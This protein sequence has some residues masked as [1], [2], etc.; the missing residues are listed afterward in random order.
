MT[1]APTTRGERG[2]VYRVEPLAPPPPPPPALPL[3]EFFD[4]V[5]IFSAPILPYEIILPLKIYYIYLPPALPLAE[6]GACPSP[7][8]LCREFFPEKARLDTAGA[9][10]VDHT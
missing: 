5:G 3:A 6:V 7:S 9:I 2:L 4:E 8:I 1:A 10:K